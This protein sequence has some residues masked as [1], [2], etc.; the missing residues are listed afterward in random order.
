MSWNR[1][2]IRVILAPNNPWHLELQIVIEHGSPKASKPW[3]TFDNGARH[4]DSSEFGHMTC[5]LPAETIGH[6]CIRHKKEKKKS[7][8]TLTFG[9]AGCTSY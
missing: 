8:S 1:C 9:V 5:S 6:H 7:P 4:E 3:N 2:G